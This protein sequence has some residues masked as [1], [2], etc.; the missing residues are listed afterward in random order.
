MLRRGL[1]PVFSFGMTAIMVMSVVTFTPKV[2]AGSPDSNR[3]TPADQFRGRLSPELVELAADPDTT[4][5]AEVRVI[6]RTQATATEL[7]DSLSRIG[8]EIKSPL[9]LIDAYVASV[10]RSAL[11]V[12]AFDDLTDYVSLD[13]EITLLT[14]Q[15]DYNLVRVTTGAENVIGR[16]GL[17]PTRGEP[18]IS[19]YLKSLPDGPNGTS[20]SIAVLDSG[21]Y[22]QGALH[23]DLRVINNPSNPRILA[24]QAR[25][26][27]R[28]IRV[29]KPHRF[30]RILNNFKRDF[31]RFFPLP[32]AA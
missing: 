11:S 10:P 14:D 29:E 4:S 15:Y 3:S 2:G 22:D 32:F 16:G 13:R 20:I 24:H 26:E 23:E 6:L 31:R 9:P 8:G 27:L 25:H 21:I 18:E 12:L 17:D 1:A 19:D 28:A 5:D 7:T 30:V